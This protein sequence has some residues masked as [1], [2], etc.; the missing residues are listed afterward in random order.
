VRSAI[1]GSSYGVA[2]VQTA[3]R[4]VLRLAAAETL[5]FEFAASAERSAAYAREVAKLAATCARRR[6]DEPADP[7]GRYEAAAD[8]QESC[9]AEAAG[10]PCPSQL[11]AAA[12]RGHRACARARRTT[13]R[14]RRAL[15][16]SGK[17]LPARGGRALDALLYTL[18]AER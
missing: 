15:E 11:R 7:R 13:T 6:T 3:G 8:P 9:S 18:G 5:P 17:P 10:P 12:E 16:K 14:R 4:V 2:L 1:P